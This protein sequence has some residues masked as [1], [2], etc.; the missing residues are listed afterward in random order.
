M[1]RPKPTNKTLYNRVS[2]RIKKKVPKHSAYRSGLIVKAYKKAGGKYSGTKSKGNL[3]RWFKEKWRNQRGGVGYKKK[4]MY[5]DLQK[6]LVRR[7]LKHL[8]S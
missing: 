8:N 1:S 4:E 3:G 2:A 7:H 6:E 5:I